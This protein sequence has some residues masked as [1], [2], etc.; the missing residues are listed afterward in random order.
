MREG[1]ATIRRTSQIAWTMVLVGVLSLTLLNMPVIY[2]DMA[3]HV[4]HRGVDGYSQFNSLAALGSVAGSVLAGRFLAPA[5]L[6]VLT[7]SLGAIAALMASAALSPWPALF[8]T[9]IL[10]AAM[11]SVMFTLRASGLVQMSTVPESR[12]RVMSVYIIVLLGGQAIGG[13]I[14]GRFVDAVGGRTALMSSALVAAVAAT[15]LAWW[16]G[17]ASGQTQSLSQRTQARA[18]VI[19]TITPPGQRPPRQ[20]HAHL[21][22]KARK[23]G[24]RPVD[25]PARKLR[26][27][28]VD[29][30]RG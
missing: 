12:G 4:F 10:L 13:P 22:H 7:I 19:F 8:G 29:S 26:H 9:V 1:I 23:L 14:M 30:P 17:H 6:R 15:I 11:M 28:S 20:H 3:T 5:R 25:L 27:P 16:M 24:M 18:R 21:P 2:A